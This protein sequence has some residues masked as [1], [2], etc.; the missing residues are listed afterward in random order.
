MLLHLPEPNNYAQAQ[1]LVDV[2]NKATDKTNRILHIRKTDGD[3][4]IVVTGASSADNATASDRMNMT[5]NATNDDAQAQAFI[6]MVR[7]WRLR[8]R[9]MTPR[10]RCCW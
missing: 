3:K 6:R 4:A 10:T 5:G 7:L 1:G 9:R 2:F 8:G